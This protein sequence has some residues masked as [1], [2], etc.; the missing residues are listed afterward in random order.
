MGKPARYLLSTIGQ[1]LGYEVSRRVPLDRVRSLISLLRPMDAGIPLI[2][3]GAAGDGGYLVPDDLQGIAACLSPGVA[4]VADFELALQRRG[5][6]SL[7]ADHSV[8]A[9]PPGCEHLPFERRFVGLHDHEP[10]TTLESWVQRWPQAATGDLLLQMDI[11]GAEWTVLANMTPRLLT[12]FRM[13]VIELHWMEAMGQ[14]FAMRVM[15]DVLDRLHHDF[16]CVHVHP[17][18]NEGMARIGGIPVPRAI[19]VTLLRRDRV[20][21]LAPRNDF[22]HSLDR[23]NVDG[24]PSVVLPPEWFRTAP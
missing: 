24:K 15:H 19:E 17:N 18:N 14:P 8:Q 13:M 1:A 22:P 4:S 20:R 16:V 12:R 7:L 21:S 6:P 3:L 2:R 9:P 5:I 10:F 23:D 11:E